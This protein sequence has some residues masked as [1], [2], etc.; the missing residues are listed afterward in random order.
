MKAAHDVYSE[1][2]PAFC[3]TV[4][5][6]FIDAYADS[7][8]HGPDLPLAY[9]ALPIALSSDLGPTFDGTNKKTGL[10]TWLQRRPEIQVGLADR[11]NDTLGI[12]TEA[13]RFGAFTKVVVVA[14][15]GHLWMGAVKVKASAMKALGEGP[16]QA[17]RRAE[18]L[19]H[20]FADAGST[21]TVF[22]A[23]G[24]TV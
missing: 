2:N 18:R 12:V 16:T 6:A 3:A 10:P 8:G 4:L 21:R 5:A 11:I 9:L 14:P 13:I 23:M 22:D 20:W 15:E 7:V 24:L 1:T 17:I 19:G